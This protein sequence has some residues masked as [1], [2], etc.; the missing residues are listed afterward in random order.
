MLEFEIFNRPLVDARQVLIDRQSELVLVGKRAADI[1]I[2]EQSKRF[3]RTPDGGWAPNPD[4]RS[5]RGASTRPK[6]RSLC[7]SLA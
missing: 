3:I 6:P 4:Y 5:N 1:S 7:L 2:E